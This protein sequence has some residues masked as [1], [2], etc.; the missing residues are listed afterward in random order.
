[1]QHRQKKIEKRLGDVNKKIPDDSGLLTT[2]ALN[3]KKM[4]SWE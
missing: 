4:R 1:M 2:T 3:T